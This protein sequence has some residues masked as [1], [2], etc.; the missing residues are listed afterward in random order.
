MEEDVKKTSHRI[1]FKDL[2]PQKNYLFTPVLIYANI[3]VFLLMVLFGMNVFTPSIDTLIRWGGNIRYLTINGQ[4]WRLFTCVFLHGGILHLVFNMYALL[5]AGS[6]LERVIGKDKFLFAYIISGIA[7]SVASLIIHESV[8]SVGASG[9]IFGLFGVLLPL[10]AAKECNFQNI[11][12]NKMLLNT[13]IFVLYSIMAGFN[14]SG[15]DNAA[16]IG[17]LL[18]GVMIGVFYSLM[19]KGRIRPITTYIILTLML[20]SFFTLAITTVS[21]KFGEFD[22]VIKEISVNEQKALWM[23]QEN[24]DTI[25]ESRLRYYYKEK[26]TKEGIEIWEENVLLLEKIKSNDYD[27]QFVKLIDILIDYSNLRKKSCELMV[28][29][30]DDNSLEVRKKLVETHINIEN[31]LKELAENKLVNYKQITRNN[32]SNLQ[33]YE[34]LLQLQAYKINAFHTIFYNLDMPIEEVIILGNAVKRLKGYFPIHQHIDIIF[35]NDNDNYTIKLFV[36]K[37]FWQQPEIVDRLKSTIDY[38]KNSGIEK[39]INLVMIDNQTFEEKNV[40]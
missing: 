21:D 25:P 27:K 40:E 5:Y 29:S 8:V 6:I 39:P 13:S 14:T 30:I 19:A 37:N 28:E 17:G 22:R 7:A 24:L 23:Y 34:P 16:H 9:A 1:R 10:L 11:S 36:S 18:T 15:I 3:F 12:I 26:L 33:I 32:H 31:K 35:L 2:F 38:V 20:I 4:L